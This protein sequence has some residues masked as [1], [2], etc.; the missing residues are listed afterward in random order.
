MK[1][2][3]KNSYKYSYTANEYERREIERI[4]SHYQDSESDKDFLRLK[5]LDRKVRKLPFILS[6]ILGVI[7]ILIFGTGLTMVLEWSNYIWGIVVMLVGCIPIAF[8]RP[9]HE[10]LYKRNNEKY[11][12]EILE[13]SERLL[14][15]REKRD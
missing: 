3:N 13:L 10:I 12:Q 6:L 14:E 7:G 2:D 4:R 11:R 9:L 5:K 15:E 1:E 8:A